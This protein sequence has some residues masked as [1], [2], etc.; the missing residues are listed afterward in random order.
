MGVSPAE[1]RGETLR[2]ASGDSR[3]QVKGLLS[4]YSPK[5]DVSGAGRGMPKVE[6][7]VSFIEV[8]VV[9]AHLPQRQAG[10][11]PSPS[12]RMYCPARVVNRPMGAAIFS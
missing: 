11:L 3:L 9:S 2:Q 12:P 10:L 7:R 5:Q 6:C 4:L 1:Y 8:S